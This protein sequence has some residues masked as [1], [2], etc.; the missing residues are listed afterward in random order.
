MINKQLIFDNLQFG[1]TS[2]T[3]CELE[4]NFKIQT[5]AV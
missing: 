4:L 1:G 5:Q 2:N 3:T